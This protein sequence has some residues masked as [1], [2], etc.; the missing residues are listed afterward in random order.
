[1]KKAILTIF[2]L[3]FLSMSV[4]AQHSLYRDVKA[5]QVG[6][7]ITVVLM[8][9]ISG[10][11]SS[12]ARRSSNTNGQA[13]GSVSG[14]FLPFEPYF[15]SNATMNFNDDHRNLAN[16]RQLLQGHLSVQITEVTNR[17]DLLVSGSR[18]TE[19]NGELHEISLNG[20]V[21]SND[22][23]SGNRIPSYRVANA[24]INYQMKGGVKQATKRQGFTRRVIFAGIG[25]AM[26]AVII[27]REL[28]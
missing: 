1:M 24:E 7:I 10:S 17:G 16:Q 5:N 26:G 27:A 22:I 25:A 11:S 4:Q 18:V 9:N 14:N 19:I 8:E 15:G 12:D 28:N 13:G 20:L 23:D 6:D 2:T 3:V 21:R